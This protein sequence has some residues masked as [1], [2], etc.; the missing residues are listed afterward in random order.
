MLKVLVSDLIP[1][2]DTRS[3]NN[4]CDVMTAKQQKTMEVGK[5]QGK[6]ENSAAVTT[7]WTPRA[8][9]PET[10]A[11][12]LAM[13]NYCVMTTQAIAAEKVISHRHSKLLIFNIFM[14]NV[15]IQKLDH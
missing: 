8:I 5:R 11:A 13:L 14:E 15:N 12:G 10:A 4:C 1:A 9:S 3:Q 2:S 6:Q 7:Q